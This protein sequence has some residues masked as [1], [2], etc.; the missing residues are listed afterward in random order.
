ML[1]GRLLKT[2][3]TWLRL[4]GGFTDRYFEL[5]HNGPFLTPRMNRDNWGFVVRNNN[6]LGCSMSVRSSSHSATCE[7]LLEL[8]VKNLIKNRLRETFIDMLREIPAPFIFDMDEEAEFPRFFDVQ[9][10]AQTGQNITFYGKFSY[11]Q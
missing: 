6:M 5:Y 1:N 2:G 8:D 3:K 4:T 7:A 10:K 11:L 9:S